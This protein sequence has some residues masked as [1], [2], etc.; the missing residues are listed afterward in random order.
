M[1]WIAAQREIPILNL[2]I[3]LSLHSNDI[4]TLIQ[5]AF[6]IYI[7][8]TIPIPIDE[9]NQFVPMIN[10]TYHYSQHTVFEILSKLIFV[11]S[12]ILLICRYIQMVILVHFQLEIRVTKLLLFRV[13]CHYTGIT[14]FIMYFRYMNRAKLLAKILKTNTKDP[15]IWLKILFTEIG[16]H[17][18]R[19]SPNSRILF[20]IALPLCISP[21]IPKFH[22]P[23]TILWFENLQN[24]ISMGGYN[25]HLVCLI[26]TVIWIFWGCCH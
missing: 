13:V 25:P 17:Y 4:I 26:L 10:N 3:P 23:S 20:P 14:V 15:I 12:L 5:V 1:L 16:F 9:P 24:S 2:Q 18:Q 7:S 8:I 11:N 19:L 22:N 21:G 6:Y